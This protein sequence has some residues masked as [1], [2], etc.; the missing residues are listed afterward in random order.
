MTTLVF[1]HKNPDTDSVASAIALANLKQ[2]L[3]VKTV[4]YALGHTNKETQFALD[5]FGVP[6]PQILN[7]VKTQ[8]KDLDYDVVEAIRPDMS[9]LAAYKQMEQTN[10]RTLAVVN[11]D[12]Q[13]LGLVTMKDIAMQLIK[14]DFYSLHT[15]LANL[16]Q[17][18]NGKIIVGEDFSQSDRDLVGNISIIA[19]YYKTIAGSLGENDIIIVGDRYDIIEHAIISKVKLIILTA[20]TKLPERFIELAKE[21]DVPILSVPMDTYTTSKLMSQCNYVCSIMVSDSIVKFADEHYLDDIKEEI[22]HTQYR[23]Y[24]VVNKQNVFLGFINKKHLLSPGKKKVI[25]VDHNETAQS[26]EGLKEAEIL[27]VIDHHKIGDI[28]TSLPISFRNMPVGS[29]CTIVYRMYQEMRVPLNH[30]MAGLLLAGII[31]DTLLFKSPTTTELDRQAVEELNNI[32]R[33]DIEQYAMEMFKVGT[34]LEGISIEEIFYKDFK[35]FQVGNQT[36]GVSQVC[37]L[38]TEDVLNRQQQFGDFLSKTHVDKGYV[39][40]LLVI[41]DIMKEGSYLLFKSDNNGIISTAFKVEAKQGVF[42]PGMVS[43]KK[44]VVPKVLEAIRILQ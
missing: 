11:Q 35:E 38:D 3:G 14:G 6:A 29:T 19:Y 37:T 33:L 13:F 8:V 1:G 17:D 4:P 23:N 27:E 28:T 21:N 39:T 30:S 36:I 5:Y 34:S 31:S 26:A 22:I 10:L 15:S 41:T 12:N 20:E 16:V 9:I 44:Q 24:P 43:R 32:L 18:L 2:Q 40:T 25:L 42:V 7:N